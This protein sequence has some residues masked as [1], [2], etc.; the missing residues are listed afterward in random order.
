MTISLS[1]KNVGRWRTPYP[2][3]VTFFGEQLN[4]TKIEHSAILP[5]EKNTECEILH[6]Y[7]KR[8]NG[9]NLASS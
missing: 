4:V 9:I 7:R 8:S 5:N 6:P 3:I 2:N 1:E